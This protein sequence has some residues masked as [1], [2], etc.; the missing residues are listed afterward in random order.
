MSRL[1]EP[2]TWAGVSGAAAALASRA[3]FEHLRASRVAAEE[4]KP[5]LAEAKK[6]IL[7]GLLAAALAWP[8]RRS[9]RA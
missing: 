5:I 7:T 2:S 4:N 3:D 6:T 9:R 1:K 8:D